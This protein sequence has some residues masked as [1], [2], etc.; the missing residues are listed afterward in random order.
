[1]PHRLAPVAAEIDADVPSWT[2]FGASFA[3]DLMRYPDDPEVAHLS[4]A[5]VLMGR[6]EAVARR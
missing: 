1:V 5:T 3:V 4:R 2:L 6:D